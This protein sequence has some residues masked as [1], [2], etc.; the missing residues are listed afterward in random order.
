M[1]GGYM[2]KILRVNL[3]ERTISIEDLDSQVETLKQF[4]GGA[5]LSEKYLYD[6]NAGEIDPLNEK[7][8][9]IF[10]TGP[11]CG[12]P[13]PTSGRHSVV[14][15]SPLTGILG[16]SDCGG[17]WG[18]MLKK[19]GFDGIIVQGESKNPAYL[20]IT[21]GEAEIRDACELWGLD[22]Y[23][24]EEK[25]KAQTHE[26]AVISAIGPAG[27]NLVKFASIMSDGSHGRAAGRT[28]IGTLMGA[29]KLK[30][31]A[32]YGTEKT[33]I[34]ERKAL[35]DSI[36]DIMPTIKKRTEGVSRYGTSGG[37]VQIEKLGDLP[38]KNWR[39]GSWDSVEKI[40]G[41]ELSKKLLKGK[42]HCA[43]CPIGCGRVVEISKGKYSPVNGAGPEYEAMAALGSLIL[44]DDLEAICKANEFCNRYGLDIISTG[45]VIAFAFEAFEKG[46]LTQ[47]KTGGLR[48]LWGDA[49]AM[50]E[51]IQ[52]IAKREGIGDLLA[53]GVKQAAKQLDPLCDEFAIHTKG[54]EP[55][56]H[57]PRAH[58]GL[59]LLYAVSSIGA[60]HN[61]GQ[62]HNF[63]KVL[64]CP[65]MGIHEPSDRFAVEGK[66]EFTA[67]TEDLMCLFNSL[68]LCQ[69]SLF[70]GVTLTHIHQWLRYITGID[71]SLEELIKTGE[72]ISNLKRLY[73]VRLG[74][75]RKDD[76]LHPRF[77]S[78]KR[79]TGGSAH[80]LP[81]L[82]RMLSEYYEFRGWTQE[83]IPRLSKLR[84]LGLES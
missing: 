7:N 26:K 68:K 66:G 48:L 36:R 19:T 44:V 58:N 70:G 38:I 79:G 23:D 82:G 72:R 57:D 67:K 16:E 9:L 15:R 74:I 10:M 11:F 49:N 34:I 53:E 45:G 50:L 18:T 63:E 5:G 83:G 30:A 55:A 77:L 75:S 43:A 51:L 54:L 39:Q 60:S 73:N 81:P 14:A 52:L 27:E 47:E 61:Q 35:L 71:I 80:N 17:Y 46:I 42:F 33:N 59:A 64:T 8:L 56:M 37:I 2:G 78:H 20:W 12:T 22:T 6:E 65:E 29:K 1:I 21:N 31:I 69:F 24:L 40:S 41:I 13:V 32:V 25:I 28:G 4:I 84:E 76:V 62:T 3:T